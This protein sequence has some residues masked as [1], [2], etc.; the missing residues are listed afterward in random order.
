MHP[1]TPS[2]GSD[3]PVRTGQRMLVSMLV[4]ASSSSP[5][6]WACGEH[7]AS[8]TPVSDFEAS[9]VSST[10]ASEGGV[11]ALLREVPRLPCS[12]SPSSLPAPSGHSGVLSRA[13]GAEG[14]WARAQVQQE[15]TRRRDRRRWALGTGSG[16]YFC[17]LENGNK[18]ITPGFVKQER[19]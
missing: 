17:A 3:R 18:Q 16:S 4:G 2:L 5:L 19:Q 15:Q 12:L 14:G 8:F 11:S 13:A 9:V 6:L 1:L 10:D 7:G